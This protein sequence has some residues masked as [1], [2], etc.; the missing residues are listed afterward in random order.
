MERLK[1]LWIGS[2]SLAVGPLCDPRLLALDLD[3]RC[4]KCRE[5]CAKW[6]FRDARRRL[7]QNFRNRCGTGRGLHTGI[8]VHTRWTH[9]IRSDSNDRPGHVVMGDC[10]RFGKIGRHDNQERKECSAD[11]SEIAK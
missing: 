5:R 7:L 8:D 6:D 9:P 4:S 11:K 3:R 1:S 10:F 2:H